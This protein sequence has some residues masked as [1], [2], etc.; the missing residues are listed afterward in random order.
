[1]P[2]HYLLLAPR[3]LRL[4]T[5]DLPPLGPHDVHLRSRLGAISSGTE[6][7]WYFGTDPQLAWSANIG[8]GDSRKQR[9]TADPVV[10]NGRVFTLILVRWSRRRR[11]LVR[12]CGRAI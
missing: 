2:Q 6:S 9:I 12:P 5:F 4:E 3:D 7:A 8:A 11:H 10:A 1:M